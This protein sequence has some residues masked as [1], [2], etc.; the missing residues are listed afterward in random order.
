V[1]VETLAAARPACC[2]LL[3]MNKGVAGT[4]QS[5]STDGNLH[6]PDAGKKL[7]SHRQSTKGRPDSH[8]KQKRKL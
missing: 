7:D 2:T 8:S 3:V 5:T 1:D 6:R 4:K